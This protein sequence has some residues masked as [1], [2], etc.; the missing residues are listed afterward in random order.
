MNRMIIK[1]CGMRDGENIREIEEAGADWMGFIFFRRSPRYVEELPA[2]LPAKVKR[3]G[4]FVN[5]SFG[6][7]R[8]TI[9]RFGL[10]MVQ[11]H[12]DEPPALCRELRKEGVEVIKSF[13]IGDTF[14]AES[15]AAYEGE[16]HYFLFDTKTTFYG[17][18]G[19]KF[20]WGILGD[21]RDKTPFL[22]SGGISPG[23][24]EAIKAFSHPGCI[25]IDLNSGFEISPALKNVQLLQT[26]ID[27]VR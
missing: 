17:G 5:E 8:E 20:N 10:D 26:F 6:E 14:S 25:G 4:V 3:V 24:V 2:Y 12:G 13:S 11:L 21:Y 23:D 18:S 16:C 27:K 1:V 7:I 9:S 19:R 15:T 22:L